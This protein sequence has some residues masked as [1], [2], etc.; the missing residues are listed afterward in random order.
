M[1]IRREFNGLVIGIPGIDYFVICESG[2][3]KICVT[4]S[5]D[6]ELTF[7]FEMDGDGIMVGRPRPFI[8]PLI[9]QPPSARDSTHFR[10]R[11][12]SL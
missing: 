4:D 9:A 1:S 10:R 6:K 5:A 8:D 3:H 2:D 12:L 7:E 11:P